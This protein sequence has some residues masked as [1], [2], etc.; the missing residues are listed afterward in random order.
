MTRVQ[1]RRQAAEDF[2]PLPPSP[3]PPTEMPSL[4]M[5]DMISQVCGSPMGSISTHTPP[6]IS[7]IP[8]QN[9]LT[10]SLGEDFSP[11]TYRNGKKGRTPAPT[12]SSPVPTHNTYSVLPEIVDTD[13]DQPSPRQ[14]IKKPRIPPIIVRDPKGYLNHVRAIKA[15]LTGDIS[16]A[17]RT[18]SVKYQL[19]TIDDFKT[20]IKYLNEQN[21]PYYTYEL[22]EVKLIKVVIKNLSPHTPTE[23][24]LEALQ[25]LKFPVQDVKQMT[26]RQPGNKK[27]L[28]MFIAYMTNRQ[29]SRDIYKLERL[30]YQT[31]K[32][33]AYKAPKEISQCHR[34]QLWGHGQSNCTA[35]HTCVK[36]GGKH[37][38]K[39]CTKKREEAPKCAN[40]GGPHPA[41][42]KKCAAYQKLIEAAKKRA[43]P[44]PT[45]QTQQRH[46]SQIRNLRSPTVSY[47]NATTGSQRQGNAA[48]QL[49]A[50]TVTRPA[51][52]QRNSE[53]SA[54]PATANTKIHAQAAAPDT[55]QSAQPATTQNTHTNTPQDNTL[56]TPQ[57]PTPS[58]NLGNT[59]EQVLKLFQGL[60]LN[61]LLTAIQN[62]LTKIAQ[63]DDLM[64]KVMIIITA[65]SAYQNGH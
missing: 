25:D 61:R 4:A 43:E 27:P 5:G 65:I 32:V 51:A 53:P 34:C 1:A 44:K 11:V 28:P 17:Y 55:K 29:D 50:N 52:G 24:I 38:T 7:P 64:T 39:L 54:R 30:L 14:I 47:A 59:I 49:A 33:E 31:I 45:P 37:D 40:C 42:Y 56:N 63:T 16:V 12:T 21:I 41:N 22:D 13:G 46:I 62:A 19:T 20:T 36:C 57:T 35:Q 23:D 2:P 26:S 60:D 18:E 9:S 10:S 48:A 3:E 15:K 8:S 6:L 58:P